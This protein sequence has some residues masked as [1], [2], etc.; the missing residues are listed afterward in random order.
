MLS[1]GPNQDRPL[2]KWRYDV[3]FSIRHFHLNIYIYPSELSQ[4]GGMHQDGNFFVVLV[5]TAFPREGQSFRPKFVRTVR[6]TSEIYW[7]IRIQTAPRHWDLDLY[8][9]SP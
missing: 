4:F 6:K 2:A 9:C 3:H 1:F 8:L 7:Q 5:G